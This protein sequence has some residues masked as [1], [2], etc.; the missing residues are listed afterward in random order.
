MLEREIDEL[1]QKSK[2]YFTPTQIR[3]HPSLAVKA[4]AAAAKHVLPVNEDWEAPLDQIR[5]E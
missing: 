2:Q 5:V 1:V 4:R 3:V